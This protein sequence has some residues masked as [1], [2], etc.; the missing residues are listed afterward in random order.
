[1]KYLF[2]VASALALAACGG[3]EIPAAT[4]A[5]AEHVETNSERLDAVL[6][7]QS[8]ETK[9]RY[10]YRHPKETLEFFGIEPG[11]T[12][13]DTLPGSVWYSGILSQYLGAEGKVIGAD[14]S[15]D[16]RRAMG[17]RY[18]EEAW[19]EARQ[20]W[21]QSWANERN[22]ERADN[23]APFAAFFYGSVPDDMVGT[24][25]V[26]LMVR[27]AHH[28]HKVEDSGGFFTKAIEDASRILKP[29]GIVG[30]VQHR[31]PESNSDEWALGFKGYLKQSQVITFFENAGFELA[32]ESEI[33]ANPKDQPTEED[34][35]WRL[36]P[37][38]G[39]SGEDPELR[40]TMEA[41]GESDRM[42][43]KFRK[44]E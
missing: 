19:I 9:A 31:G 40:A 4:S 41:I 8:D 27:A 14:Y 29:G 17:G 6:A 32:G 13:V 11:M 15:L 36:A 23:D 35:V 33:N 7:A 44:P 18:G 38:L 30:V 22:A 2:L 3:T 42:T 28:M 5:P 20:D 1:M 12:V 34:L 26:V 10:Q 21:P 24:A 39:T 25:D 43:L 16:Q 37:T